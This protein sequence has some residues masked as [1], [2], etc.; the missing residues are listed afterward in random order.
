MATQASP[1]YC[2]NSVKWI[3]VL[4]ILAIVAWSY[5]AYVV[6]MC[7][8]T[9]D[10]IPQKVIYLCI[11]H[12]L[13]VLFLWSYYCT[14]FRPAARPTSEFY[15]SK[16]EGEQIAATQTSE[17]R[18]AALL[19]FARQSNLPLLTRHFDG[20]IRYCFVCQCI[21]P[22]RA[23]HCS[24]CEKCVLRYDHHCPWTNSCVS[25][26]NYK[27]FILFLGW[28][29]LFCTYVSV[30][31]LEYF[32][33]FWQSTI[34]AQKTGDSSAITA[35]QF[36]LL[37]LFFVAVMFGISVSSLFFY[38]L[39]LTGK[40]RTT[41]ESYRAPIFESGPEKDGF[42]LGWKRNY[43]EIFGINLLKAFIPIPTTRGDGIHY[44]INSSLLS[45]ASQTA[46]NSIPTF[47]RSNNQ[48]NSVNNDHNY[49]LIDNLTTQEK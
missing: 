30:T 46:F 9:V 31:S 23:H 47:N 15:L 44:Q 8:F 35:R 10:S 27:S 11:Y 1:Q 48:F 7:I 45:D 6:Q 5:Y 39:F 24:T 41:L 2:Y 22:D 17:E 37:F 25:Y 38:H 42:D 21:K 34:N 14:M 26:G 28:A 32:I 4:F 36:H 43:Q 19:R 29:L 16:T 18:R 3:P 33:Q 49:L 40:N 13:L 20:S 12:L